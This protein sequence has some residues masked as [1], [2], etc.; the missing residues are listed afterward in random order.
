MLVRSFNWDAVQC[1]RRIFAERFDPG[2]LMPW[3]RRAARLDHNV[4]NLALAL[5][6]RPTASLAQ[7][8]MLPVSKDTLFR[9]VRRRS[10]PHLFPPTVIGIDN[11]RGGATS[12]MGPSIATWSGASRSPCFL[13]ARRRRRK[14]ACECGQRSD[15]FRVPVA[16]AMARRPVGRRTTLRHGAMAVPQE[17][18]GPA[19]AFGWSRSGRRA[20]DGRYSSALVPSARTVSSHDRA[21]HDHRR[22]QP[23]Q[24]RDRHVVVIEASV[25]IPVGAREIS[26]SFQTMMRKK[27]L[28][29]TLRP[30]WSGLDQAWPPRSPTGSSRT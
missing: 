23:L 3:A 25:P 17:P 22:R 1:G 19:A 18:R 4:R 11:W 20:A 2:V 21:A 9:V 12:A 5:G 6:G 15:V 14:P 26:G 27:S 16:P 13:I 10:T 29:A 8:L 24:V 28:V 7:R 30:G